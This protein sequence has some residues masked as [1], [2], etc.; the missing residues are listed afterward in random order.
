MKLPITGSCLCKNIRYEIT[1]EPTQ[2]GAC[3]C[4]S[5]QKETGSS[6]FPYLLVSEEALNI[7]GEPKWHK[8]IGDSGNPVH[9]GF[10][11][12]CGSTIF[13]HPE[14]IPG[15]HTVAAASLDNAEEY[16]PTT[17]LWTS[18]AQ[19]WGQPD[20]SLQHFKKNPG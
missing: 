16:K 20:P 19:P 7:Q 4:R 8:S 15:H 3:H 10:C 6:H 9:R 2:M 13:G 12:Q 17:A 1:E 14:V 11:P 5:C 18:D